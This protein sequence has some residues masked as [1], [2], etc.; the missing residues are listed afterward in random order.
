MWQSNEGG[1]MR[2]C[3][4]CGRAISERIKIPKVEKVRKYVT[5]YTQL[6]PIILQK[7]GNMDICIHC[8]HEMINYLIKQHKEDNHEE[9]QIQR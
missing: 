7:V 9:N 4:I 2:V 8:Y 3:D 6:D 5:G 1:N